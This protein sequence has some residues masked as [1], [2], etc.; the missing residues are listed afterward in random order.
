MIAIALL[1]PKIQ[2]VKDL[3]R[4]FSK[5]GRFRAPFKSQRV[6][7]PKTFVKSA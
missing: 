3:L 5:K 4:L 1:F 7:G 6:K 2:T